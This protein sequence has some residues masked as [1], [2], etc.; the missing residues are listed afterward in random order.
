MKIAS[1]FFIIAI[2][3]SGCVQQPPDAESD[4]YQALFNYFSKGATEEHNIVIS[5]QLISDK[6]VF[7]QLDSSKT[8]PT[9]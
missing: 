9:I 8:C 3:N 1:L 7:P 6:D 5:E 4:I 2:A